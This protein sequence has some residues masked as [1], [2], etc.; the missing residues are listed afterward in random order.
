MHSHSDLAEI[1]LDRLPVGFCHQL[2]SGG[3]PGPG[4]GVDPCFKA[5]LIIFFQRCLTRHLDSITGAVKG[6][7][8]AVRSGNGGVRS[9][10]S[11]SSGQSSRRCGDS[12]IRSGNRSIRS[13]NSSIKSGPRR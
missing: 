4:G 1:P 8:S 5:D 7:Q 13:G 11:T 12:S 9:V 3:L 10:N 2:H 6:V